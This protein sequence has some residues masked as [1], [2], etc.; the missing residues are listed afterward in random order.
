MLRGR[1]ETSEQS[2]IL[3]PLET[4]PRTNSLVSLPGDG[5]KSID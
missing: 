4:W 5:K 2:H 1:A 3:I